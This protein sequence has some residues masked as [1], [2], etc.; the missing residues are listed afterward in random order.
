MIKKHGHS[1]STR[2]ID[3]NRSFEAI[4]FRFQFSEEALKGESFILSNNQ[5]G[6]GDNRNIINMIDLQLEK[7]A[8]KGK[9]NFSEIFQTLWLKLDL[10]FNQINYL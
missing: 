8:E 5:S 1:I 4:G 3:K 7:F 9:G 6:S 2:I 10:M